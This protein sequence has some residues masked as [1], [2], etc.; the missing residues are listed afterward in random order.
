[1]TRVADVARVLLACVRLTM[2]TA[3]LLAPGMVIRRLDIDP[4]VQPGMRYPLRMFGIRTVLIAAD[5]LRRNGPD[6]RH[7]VLLAPV[8]HGTDTVSA[9]LAWRRGDLPPRA[10]TMTTA[11]SVVN[12]ILA[13]VSL[14]MAPR[15]PAGQRAARGPTRPRRLRP[16]C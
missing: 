12:L 15:P 8:V 13:L 3:G 1:M 16:R 4:S 9:Y 10:G 2:G 6:R 5:L 11:I 14:A 7:A